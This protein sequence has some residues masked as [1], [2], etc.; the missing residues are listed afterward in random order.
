MRFNSFHTSHGK[1][2]GAFPFRIFDLF[3]L[4]KLVQVLTVSWLFNPGSGMITA[5]YYTR[6][7]ALTARPTQ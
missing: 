1:L 6:S 4:L 2:S 5:D 3:P 7:T